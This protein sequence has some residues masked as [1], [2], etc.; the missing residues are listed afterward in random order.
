M[1]T[2]LIHI[3]FHCHTAATV[4]GCSSPFS[5]MKGNGGEAGRKGAEVTIR[6]NKERAD[7]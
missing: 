3:A 4:Q 6:L 2:M 7:P 1:V 5:K